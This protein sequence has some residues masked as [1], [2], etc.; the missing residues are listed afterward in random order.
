MGGDY[1]YKTTQDYYWY[2]ICNIPGIGRARIAKLLKAFESPEGVY[3]AKEHELKLI[4][5]ISDNMISSIGRE[6][7]NELLYQS[8]INL[9]KKG[10]R[11]THPGCADYPERLLDIYDYPFGLYYKGHMP[12]NSRLTVAIVG[13][14]SCSD[15][16][17]SVAHYF[18]KA[19]AGMGIQVISGLAC[20]V[21]A[22]GHKGC[23]EGD[24]HTFGVLGCGVDICYPRENIELYTRMEKTGG[25]I[26]EY[27]VGTQPFAGQFPV[28][29]RIISGLS[30]VV[31][32][33]EARK[34][35][36][37][38]IT[39]DQALEQN[40][41][42]M[43]V[44]GRIG[45]RLSEGCNELIKMGA[46]M[47]TVPEDVLNLSFNDKN[48]VVATVKRK[49]S[50]QYSIN[51]PV[52]GDNN[53]NMES[54]K[55]MKN[56]NI[57]ATPKDMLYSVLDLTPMTLNDIKSKTDLP[58]GQ[59]GGLLFELELDGLVKEIAKNTYVKV[60]FGEKL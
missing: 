5:G 34:K 57:L 50:E 23:L 13:S 36:G 19:F 39:V 48:G 12:E 37:S 6:K 25:I 14:R 45:E 17:R 20:G 21:D 10:I 28:R 24:G 42:V 58:L 49:I 16:G 9:E 18:G 54:K 27:A 41:E 38:L 29:N 51:M 60:Q 2:W 55:S 40:R 1:I 15:Y 44:P 30:D 52:K 53:I 47:I 32:V 8:Y 59:I 35:S 11:F 33:V 7:S 43:V 31:I 26:S 3:R 56:K 4:E 22:A 46:A